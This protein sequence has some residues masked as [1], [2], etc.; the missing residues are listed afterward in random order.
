MKIAFPTN[1][2]DKI[3]KHSSFSRSFLI[4]DTETQERT[5][6]ANPVQQMTAAAEKSSDKQSGR[7]L[8]T[9]RI[10][11][12]LLA[13]AGVDLYVCFE[14]GE[15]FI[16]HLKQRGITVYTTQE[17]QI[18]SALQEAVEKREET[19]GLHPDRQED[20]GKRR[21]AGRGLGRRR[22]MDQDENRG[23][24]MGHFQGRR[25]GRGLGQG[26]GQNER[27]GNGMRQGQGR[28]HERGLGQN[29]CQNESQ[30][31][32]MQQRQGRRRGCQTVNPVIADK[33]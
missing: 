32:G 2:G 29:T 18:E 7:H 22:G 5:T 9:G 11:A 21:G 14:A 26:G 10:V 13:D 24:G 4:I 1:K 16:A 23:R 33:Q 3:V 31:R 19:D 20:H 6:L 17:R 25:E 15:K 8:G 30:G 12:A 28:K 27:Q